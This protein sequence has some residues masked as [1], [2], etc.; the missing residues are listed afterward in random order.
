MRSGLE[1]RGGGVVGAREDD[2][3]RGMI[4]G[5]GR[6]TKVTACGGHGEV[7]HTGVLTAEEYRRAAGWQ[8]EEGELRRKSNTNRRLESRF[9][10]GI[11]QIVSLF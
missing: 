1:G 6:L 7:A 3:V 8:E 5:G 11:L 10:K 4:V 9:F 2:G